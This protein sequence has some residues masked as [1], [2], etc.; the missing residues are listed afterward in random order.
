M[1]SGQEACGKLSHILMSSKSCK[2]HV[3]L[4]PAIRRSAWDEGAAH[5][6]RLLLKVLEQG[7]LEVGLQAI[8][9]EPEQALLAVLVAGS[10]VLSSIAP[11]FTVHAGSGAVPQIV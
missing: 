7:G 3:W 4:S 9:I 2:E 1:F 8:A 10:R 5:L 6:Q 11:K